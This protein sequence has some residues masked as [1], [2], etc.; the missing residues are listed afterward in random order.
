MIHTVIASLQPLKM[1]FIF[2]IIIIITYI[3]LNTT[4]KPK[5]KLR[6][7]IVMKSVTYIEAAT[8]ASWLKDATLKAG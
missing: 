1:T 2:L 3:F 5:V 8:L 6:F 7:L 4:N